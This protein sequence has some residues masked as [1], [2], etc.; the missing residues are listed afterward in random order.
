MDSDH[1]IITGEWWFPGSKIRF[2][3]NLSFN[4]ADGGKLTIFGSVDPF[5]LLDSSKA[6]YRQPR[7]AS[8]QSEEISK[9]AGCPS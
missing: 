3:G 7:R 8:I 4:L 2:N 6:Q 5:V 9:I 1:L